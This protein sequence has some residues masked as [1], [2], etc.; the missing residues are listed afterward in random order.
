MLGKHF[1]TWCLTV[2]KLWVESVCKNVA[3]DEKSTQRDAWN[4]NAKI[5][6]GLVNVFI[7]N[8]IIPGTCVYSLLI[9]SNGRKPLSTNHWRINK[10]LGMGC[11]CG[12]N[13]RE[14][15]NFSTSEEWAI[16]NSLMMFTNLVVHQSGTTDP[17]IKVLSLSWSHLHVW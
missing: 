16:N 13:F 7:G 2:E 5:F 11:T 4:H 10:S 1:K 15:F 3:D 8:W 17:I 6:S 14:D 12:I 9:K